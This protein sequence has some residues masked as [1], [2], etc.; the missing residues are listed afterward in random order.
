MICDKQK[1]PRPERVWDERL[2]PVVPPTLD[3]QLPASKQGNPPV[4]ADSLLLGPVSLCAGTELAGVHLWP[5]PA[6]TL[7]RDN[8]GGSGTG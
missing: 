4:R 8:G 5:R 1:T 3:W 7:S 2:T 6:D